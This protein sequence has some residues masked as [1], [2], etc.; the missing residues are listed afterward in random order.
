MFDGGN[1]LSTSLA[2][3]FDYSHDQIRQTNIF[4]ANSRYFTK[5]YPGALFML[6]ADNT[7]ADSFLVN[8]YL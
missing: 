3:D 6:A 2:D 7:G 8:I 1:Y 4:G 5:K